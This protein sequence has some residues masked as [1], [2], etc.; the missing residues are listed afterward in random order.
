[1][2]VLL[3]LKLGWPGT[4]EKGGSKWSEGGRARHVHICVVDL[5]NINICV[6]YYY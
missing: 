2:V 1:M 6:R 4:H 3:I 5:R